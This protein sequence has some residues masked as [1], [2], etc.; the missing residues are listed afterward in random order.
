MQSRLAGTNRSDRR[1]RWTRT[2]LAGKS[3]QTGGPIIPRPAFPS[4][5]SWAAAS[6]HDRKWRYE[7][8]AHPDGRTFHATGR[9]SDRNTGGPWHKAAH[10][11]SDDSQITI[12]PAIQPRGAGAVA[13][14]RRHRLRTHERPWGPAAS[15]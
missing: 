7:E 10:R 6:P 5:W 12:Q 8:A 9:C 2:V 13:P 15:S 11:R 3:D 1:R 4:D 14:R